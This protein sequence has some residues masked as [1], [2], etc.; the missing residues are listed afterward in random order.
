MK[1]FY[2]S[3]TDEYDIKCLES[4]GKRLAI[5]AISPSGQVYDVKDIKD[6]TGEG[7]LAMKI[8]AAIK[9]KPQQK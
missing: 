3:K 2:N 6:L 1:A 5:K 4:D 9:A 7:E 8:E